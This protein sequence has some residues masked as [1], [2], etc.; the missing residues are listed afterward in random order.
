M[1]KAGVRRRLKTAENAALKLLNWVLS[2][3]LGA[4]IARAEIRS[5]F[6]PFSVAFM[7]V[8]PTA[9][10][11]ISGAYIG[12]AAGFITKAFSVQNFR[13]I[14]ADTIMAAIILISGKKTYIKKVFTPVLPAAVCL[15]SGILFLFVKQ[16]DLFSVLLLVCETLLCGC[17]AYFGNYFIRAARRGVM[18]ETRDIISANITV[19]VLVCALNSF[20]I[21]GVSLALVFVILLIFMCVYYFD[22]KLAAVFLLPICLANVC[23][24]A[25]DQQFFLVL[26]IPTLICMLVSRFN[27]RYI[28]TS[29]Y[30]A[31]FTIRMSVYG[32]FG[33]DLNCLLAP[34]AAA[35]I[36]R[37]LPKNKIGA[38]LSEYVRISPDRGGREQN[39]GELCD[40]YRKSAD[41]LAKELNAA[42]IR[43]IADVKT[44]TNIKRYLFLNKC[45]DITCANFFTADG[46]QIISLYFK[47][48]SPPAP[49]AI[50]DKLCRI[51]GKNFIVSSVSEDGKNRVMK[52]EQADKFKVDCYALYKSKR[53]ENVCGDNVC[54]FKSSNSV[55]NIIL[56]DG[57]GS[58]KDANIK[59][60]NTITLLKKLLKSGVS[61]EKAIDAVNSSMGMLRDEVGFSTIDLCCISLESGVASF[62]KCGAY[63]G[64]ILKDK[65]LTKIS[66]GG[67]PAGLMDKIS[68]TFT[69]AALDDGDIIVMCSDGVSAAD[70]K[71]Q[72][73][74][75]LDSGGK[76]EVLTRRLIDSA[77]ACTPPEL[78]DDMTVL[79]AKISRQKDE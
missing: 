55:Y 2:A 39:N 25:Y 58:G 44:E 49:A 5:L 59:S 50:K 14:C 46:R 23:C 79:T 17:C 12:S 43:P 66:G 71:L 21:Y 9:G 26:Y 54:A 70:E 35:I 41:M 18:L 64:Y 69:T 72:A 31:F 53:G 74:M 10:L 51:S 3:L 20:Y 22:K 65:K 60:S 40:S 48:E 62:Y 77:Y 13:Y 29:Y 52:F 37:L 47:S 76:A 75:L 36:F 42:E 8:C 4:L 63:C 73:E 27:K 15:A 68:Y 6:S 30:L 19:L 1:E 32:I 78:D 67:Y 56:A 24:G 28:D 45:R 38:L 7:S 16:P 33:L 34:L 11:A 57:M 61:P